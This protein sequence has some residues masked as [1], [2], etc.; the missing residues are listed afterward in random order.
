[1]AGQLVLGQLRLRLE[2][3]PAVAA[4]VAVPAQHALARHGVH[5]LQHTRYNIQADVGTVFTLQ[6]GEVVLLSN[7]ERKL[8]RSCS[9]FHPVERLGGVGGLEQAGD[10]GTFCI[11]RADSRLRRKVAGTRTMSGVRL[12]WLQETE[13]VKVTLGV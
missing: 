13:R 10:T 8:S 11:A 3:R 4:L 9:H 6:V 12:L 1:M 2:L 7:D 5:P